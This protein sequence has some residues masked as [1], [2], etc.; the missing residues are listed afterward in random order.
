MK[1]ESSKKA[2]FRHH[3]RAEHVLIEV[4]NFLRGRQQP[5]SAIKG[6]NALNSLF[7][8]STC[9]FFFS[10]TTKTF[11][12]LYKCPP[13]TSKQLVEGV[14][15]FRVKRPFT[16]V[17]KHSSFGDWIGKYKI[18]MRLLFACMTVTQI[19]KLILFPPSLSCKPFKKGSY[20]VLLALI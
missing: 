3:S 12:C 4:I 10:G 19:N 2:L 18:T 17:M 13:R 9:W 5:F 8:L 7:T 6:V 20:P 1:T 14:I 11:C 16:P 15:A